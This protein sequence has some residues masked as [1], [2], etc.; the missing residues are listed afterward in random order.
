MVQQDS[1]PP[2]EAQAQPAQKSAFSIALE[3]RLNKIFSR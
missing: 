3:S 2:P 1:A